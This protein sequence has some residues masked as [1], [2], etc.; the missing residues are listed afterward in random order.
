[1]KVMGLPSFAL[2]KPLS[3]NAC[4][5]RYA[6]VRGICPISAT[7]EADDDPEATSARYALASYSERP[8]FLSV[9]DMLSYSVRRESMS[10][11]VACMSVL[12]SICS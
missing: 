4:N 10:L 8:M 9:L 5:V 11:P 7:N 3:S 6:D 12:R 2:A 1:M